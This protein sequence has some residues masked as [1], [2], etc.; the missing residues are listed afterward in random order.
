MQIKIK[1]LYS[2]FDFY[3]YE[4]ICGCGGSIGLRGVVYILHGHVLFADSTTREVGDRIKSCSRRVCVCCLCLSTSE[5][6][7]I[8]NNPDQ[9]EGMMMVQGVTT[10]GRLTI[11]WGKLSGCLGYRI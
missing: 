6:D 9:K 10:S 2:L 8:F 3:V 11:S 4:Y 7:S 1:R 5:I